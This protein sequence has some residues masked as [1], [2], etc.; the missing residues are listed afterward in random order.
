MDSWTSPVPG[1]MSTTKIPNSTFVARMW[2]NKLMAT[3]HSD[4][5]RSC[6]VQS[7]NQSLSKDPTEPEDPKGTISSE[8]IIN[9]HHFI[10]EPSTAG[11][12]FVEP[13]PPSEQTQTPNNSHGQK[14][15]KSRDSQ[16]Q[17][18]HQCS[19]K[20][21]KGTQGDSFLQGSSSC[22]LEPVVAPSSKPWP[23]FTIANSAVAQEAQL[24]PKVDGPPVRQKSRSLQARTIIQQC[25]Q[26][27]VKVRP[28]VDGTDADWVQIEQGLV[29][30]VCFFQGATEDVTH[31]MANKFMSTKVFRKDRHTVSVLDLP[32]SVLLVPQD[33]LVGQPL[34][35]R[36]MQYKDR[37][38]PWLGAQ[39]F[40]SL[41]G[42]CRQLMSESAKCTKEG[43]KVEHGVYGQK[44]E[45]SLRS[46]E[47][48]SLLLEF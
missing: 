32:G 17:R 7:S 18:L 5:F 37:C 15:K 4:T 42:A 27:K 43:M 8:N 21:K 45:I 31:E 46:L 39:L 28:A 22:G 33:S 14:T 35:N 29:V 12:S 6:E 26:A 23:V 41:V 38:E 24:P 2:P 40:S 19:A 44:Q 1:G 25:S 36:R 16:S 34:V 47:P 48:L 13:H 3:V 10:K 30:Y 20:R 11:T 9:V